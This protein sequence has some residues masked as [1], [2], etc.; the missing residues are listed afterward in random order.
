MKK[1]VLALALVVALVAIVVGT[2][3]AYFTAEDE[4]TN[5]FTIGSVMIDIIENG[6]AT[7]SDQV[8]FE[9]P[10]MPVV[11]TQDVTQDP[12]YAAKVV[13]VENTGLNAAYIRVHIAQPVEL[14]GYLNLEFDTT[15]GG[16]A[17]TA[18]PTQ[19]WTDSDTLWLL[20]TTSSLWL[21]A[22]LLPNC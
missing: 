6:K 17:W 15:T 14:L 12:G 4:V 11:N 3:L 2:S 20:M 21:P 16:S 22:N 19:L 18:S 9:K 13:K 7:D 5:T 8:I 1:K 10:M